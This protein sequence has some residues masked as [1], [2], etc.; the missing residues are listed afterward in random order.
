MKNQK[1]WQTNDFKKLESEW[2]EKL[3]KDKFQ[4][5]E[6]KINGKLVLKQRATNCYRSSKTLERETKQRYFELLGQKLHL[7][8]EFRDEVEE[9]IIEKRS[10]GFKIKEICQILRR[11]NERNHRDTIRETLRKYEIKWRIKIK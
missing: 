8:K 10:Q 4:D 5:A 11:I 6:K 2:Y 1:F 3:E 7:E 9:F